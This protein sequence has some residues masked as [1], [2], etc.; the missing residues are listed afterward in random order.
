MSELRQIASIPESKSE[1]TIRSTK[2]D[3]LIDA[4]TE[5]IDNGHK[6]LIFTNFLAGVELV[7]E[8]FNIRG[9]PYLSMTGA[10]NNRE[11]LVQRFQTDPSLKAFIMTLKTG[12]VGLNLVA[13]DHV[14]IF[15]PWWNQSAEHQAIDRAHRIGQKNTVFTYRLISRDSIEEKIQKLQEQKKELIDQIVTTDEGSFKTL[16]ESDIDALFSN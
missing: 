5:A 6:C 7:S 16:S 15:D 13:A 2:I 12:G 4:A 11:A 1:G 9:I 8:A 10:T 3:R 14:F